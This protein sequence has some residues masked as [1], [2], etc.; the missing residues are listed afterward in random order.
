MTEVAPLRIELDDVTR[1]AVLAL[2]EEHLWNMHELS[3]PD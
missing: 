2:L 1:S 3:P